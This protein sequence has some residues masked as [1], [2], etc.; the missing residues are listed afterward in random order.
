MGIES[1]IELAETIADGIKEHGACV[2]IYGSWNKDCD[3]EFRNQL[4]EK[5][6][7]KGVE[8]VKLYDY[9]DLYIPVDMDSKIKEKIIEENKEITPVVFEQTVAEFHQRKREAMAMESFI[10]G[11]A[12]AI[13]EVLMEI[14][15]DDDDDEFDEDDYDDED[16]DDEEYDEEYNY[17]EE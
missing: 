10:N 11:M 5:L 13:A 17:D 4:S 6:R 12:Y 14:I 8:T 16:E 2:Q 7:E 1:I 3:E 9:A 15:V